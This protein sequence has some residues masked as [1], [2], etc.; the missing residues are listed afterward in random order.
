[1][2]TNDTNRKVINP[3][4][5]FVIVGICFETHNTLG[6]YCREKQYGDFIENKLKENNI[7]YERELRDDLG[8]IFD[9][10]IGGDVVLEIKAKTMITKADYYQTQRYLQISQKRL[11]LLV[12]FQSKYIRPTRIVRIDTKASERFR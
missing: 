10:L 9:F 5:S 11:A 6:R 8:N 4:L 7:P 3:E 2:I 1:M 12:N